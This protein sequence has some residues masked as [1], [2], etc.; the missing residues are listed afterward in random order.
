[1]LALEG[2]EVACCCLKQED[3]RAAEGRDC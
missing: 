1:V 3:L 2:R